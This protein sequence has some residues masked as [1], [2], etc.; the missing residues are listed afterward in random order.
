MEFVGA[1][2]GYND[3]LFQHD[4]QVH[5]VDELRD[6]VAANHQTEA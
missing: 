6:P 1:G 5:S 3:V 4:G 2:N